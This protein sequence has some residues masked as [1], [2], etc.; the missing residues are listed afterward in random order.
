[1]P[2]DQPISAEP[3]L[4]TPELAQAQVSPEA[5]DPLSEILPHEEHVAMID[6]HDAHHAASTWKEF[7]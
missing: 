1:M 4:A 2:D 7:F 6:I 3:S 5:S